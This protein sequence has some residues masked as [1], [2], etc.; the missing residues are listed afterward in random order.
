MVYDNKVID[1]DGLFLFYCMDIMGG[2]FGLLVFNINWDFVVLYYV[3]VGNVNEGICI[4][5]IVLYL[6]NEMI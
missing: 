5:F 2:F 4:S 1:V 6:R 3:V